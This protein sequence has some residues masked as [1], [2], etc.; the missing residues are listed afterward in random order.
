[1]SQSRFP[2]KRISAV[3]HR[4]EAGF[5]PG[6]KVP[7]TIYASDELLAKMLTDRTID[8]AVNVTHLPYLYKHVVVLPDGHEGYGFPIGG[9]AASDAEKG[10]VSPGGVGYDINCG[11]R[12][13]RTNLTVDDVRPRLKELL[14]TIYRM[15]PSGLGSQAIIKLTSSELDLVLTEGVKWAISKGYGWDQD[16][17]MCE[18]QGVMKG[19]DPAAVSN[20]AKSRGAPQLGSLGS[21][22]HFLEVQKVDKIFDKEAAAKYGITQENQIMVLVHTGSRGLGHQVCSDYLKIIEAA[23]KKYGIDLP[24]RELACA[25]MYSKEAENYMKAMAAALNFAWS[26][27]QMITHW[28]REAFRKVFKISEEDLG[29]KLVYD[30]AHNIAKY[31]YHNIDGSMKK[32]VVH[33]KGATRAFPA[34][35]DAIPQQYRDVGQPVLIPGSMGTSSWVLKGT[36]KAMELSFGSTAHGAGRMLSRAAAVKAYTAEKIKRELESKGVL[37]EAA[38]WRGVAEEAPAAYKNVD[39]VAEVSHAVGIATK[40]ARLVPLGVVKG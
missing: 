32:V 22:N 30:V 5:K 40:V 29:M 37:I 26:N 7:V 9:V 34:G 19:A 14:Q 38:S 1:M 20:I 4:I 3:E 13:I 18:E 28:V 6:M 24:D 27:R 12:L 11:V 17:E 23:S 35:S 2:I 21:G 8:Q 33:R 10:V 36:E 16:R 25:P 15:V 31:E 39:E